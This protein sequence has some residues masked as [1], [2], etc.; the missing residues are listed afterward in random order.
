MGPVVLCV[1]HLRW[2]IL[3]KVYSQSV[4]IHLS[5]L[6]HGENHSEIMFM[7][8]LVETL[9]VNPQLPGSSKGGLSYL[10]MEFGFVII[11]SRLFWLHKLLIV[12]SFTEIN[13]IQE[14]ENYQYIF[15]SRSIGCTVLGR[16]I[17]YYCNFD[18]LAHQLDK[19]VAQIVN[20][21]GCPCSAYSCQQ[22][23]E[24][25]KIGIAII[26]KMQFDDSNRRQDDFD[27]R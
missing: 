5:W 1:W 13:W 20:E 4:I 24:G 23:R 21:T 22:H 26:Q 15:L 17:L 16:T 2:D 6:I 19:L 18:A 27:D 9:W 3:H 11:K 12:S 7:V 25:Y 14:L 8:V 10:W